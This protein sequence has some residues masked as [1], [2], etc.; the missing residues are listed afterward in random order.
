MGR[1]YDTFEVLDGTFPHLDRMVGLDLT[2][3]LAS[4]ARDSK[5]MFAIG[6][7]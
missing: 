1:Q 7:H 4:A 6:L 2:E 3:N 5:K